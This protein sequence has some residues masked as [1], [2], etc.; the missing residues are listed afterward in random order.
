MRAF[1]AEALVHQPGLVAER[2]AAPL[3]GR[4]RAADRR[5]RQAA[6]HLPRRARRALAEVKLR[7][8]V[9]RAG[10]QAEAVAL[11]AQLTAAHRYRPSR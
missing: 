11:R 10:L 6:Q 8:A 1:Q 7:V 3:Q 4:Q 5:R 9:A 2:R